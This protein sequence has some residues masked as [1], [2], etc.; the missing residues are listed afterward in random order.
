ML[1][2]SFVVGGGETKDSWTWFL[3]LLIDNLG[4]K[5]KC[6]TYTFIYEKQ[7]V[8]MLYLCCIHFNIVFMLCFNIN[9]LL[10]MSFYLV[11]SKGFMFVTYTITLGIISKKD[12]EK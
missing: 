12:V 5:T 10:L 6:R 8:N 4:G 9:Y 11:S 3:E 7:N 1:P 2:I